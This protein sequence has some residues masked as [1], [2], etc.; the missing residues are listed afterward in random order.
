MKVLIAGA[1]G[2]IGSEMVRQ[3]HHKNVAVNYLTTCKGK[4]VSIKNYNGFYW[5]PKEGEIN[6]KCFDGISAI[7]NLAGASISKRWTTSYKKELF[8]SRINSLRTLHKALLNVD[9]GNIASIVSSSAI[10]VY[11]TSLINLYTEDEKEVDTG[12]LGDLVK[13]W[14]NEMDAFKD[15]GLKVVKIRIGL[16]LSSKGGALPEMSRPINYYVGAA[17]GTGKQ[18]QSWIYI[19]DLARMF[20][21]VIEKG[22]QGVYNGVAPN[23]VTNSKLTKEIADTLNKPL[24]LPNIPQI[25]MKVLLGEMA[26]ILF[27]SQRVSSKKIEEN[28]FVFRYQNISCAL[29]ASLKIKTE[30]AQVTSQGSEYR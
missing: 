21:F 7:I 29:E 6:L 19:S 13:A 11:P 22:L 9:R 26:S 28:G 3:Y 17:F 5:D 16:V 12:F 18:W 14:E 4:I 15:L 2:L 10:G 25:V 30:N 27:A 23:P 24:L 8:L 20:L 1:T